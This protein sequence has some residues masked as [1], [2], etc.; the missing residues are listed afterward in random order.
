MDIFLA[1][2]P[3]FNK[4]MDVYGY[5]LLYRNNNVKN[6][7]QF[8]DAKEASLEVIAAS[9]VVIGLT[10]LTGGKKAFINFTEDL[11]QEEFAT[12]LP[13]EDLIIEVLEDVEP[14]KENVEACHNL[15]KAGYKIALDDFEYKA[16]YNDLINISSIIKV[17][18]INSSRAACKELINKYKN[19]KILFLAE[20]IETQEDFECALAM[21]YSLFQG[22]HFCK[23]VILSAKKVEP[24]KINAIEL[25]KLVN[26]DVPNFKE[27]AKVIENDVS[28]SFNLLKLV[29]SLA[30]SRGTKIKSILQA[31]S[32]LGEKE[33]RKWITLVA[34]EK[35][36]SDKTKELLRLS[37]IRAKFCE[38]LC[39]KFSLGNRKTE[40]FLLG[41]FSLMDAMMDV[42]KEDVFLELPISEELKEALIKQTGIFSDCYKIMIAYERANWGLVAQ[43]A[44]KYK[45]A[46]AEIATAYYESV[47]WLN[48]NIE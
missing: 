9:F 21:G 45:L 20:K 44:V 33:I 8:F 2:Q 39:H 32:L 3:I 17:D 38:V 37:I 27:I 23:P 40:L 26:E 1:R 5:E 46:E 18:F 29:N 12:I 31:I 41:L 4:N 11:L 14:T 7:C 48:N 25:I 22:Y 28:L 10:K 35:I 16:A 47:K 34:I 36:S 42:P 24:F 30:F 43:I 15:V 13:K 6:L 19:S